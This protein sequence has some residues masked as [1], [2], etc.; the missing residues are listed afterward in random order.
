MKSIRTIFEHNNSRIRKYSLRELALESDIYLAYL[1]VFLCFGYHLK[2]S[3]IF[4]LKY[5]SFDLYPQ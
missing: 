5:F 4:Q 1:E 2:F 3:K